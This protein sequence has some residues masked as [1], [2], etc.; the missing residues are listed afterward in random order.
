MN[1]SLG[2]PFYSMTEDG[3]FDEMLLLTVLVIR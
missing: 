1:I 2:L 3:L